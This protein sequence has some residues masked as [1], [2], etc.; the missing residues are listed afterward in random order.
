MALPGGA[1]RRQISYVGEFWPWLWR[2]IC[3]HTGGHSLAAR[4]LVGHGAQHHE[5]AQAGQQQAQV[6]GAGGAVGQL[7][8]LGL[9]LQQT[10]FANAT[11]RLLNATTGFP[12][13]KRGWGAAW[14]LSSRVEWGLKSWGGGRQVPCMDVCKLAV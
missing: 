10:G 4:A 1:I 5:V 6:E 12:I 14:A 3:G 2:P 8:G 11:A 9:L 13:E 7:A